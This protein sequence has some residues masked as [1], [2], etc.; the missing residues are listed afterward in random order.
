[1]TFHVSPLLSQT[2]LQY[3]AGRPEKGTAVAKKFDIGDLWDVLRTASVPSRAVIRDCWVKSLTYSISTSP[4]GINVMTSICHLANIGIMDVLKK[5]PVESPSEILMASESNDKVDSQALV[6]Y[7]GATGAKT[8]E[9][10]ELGERMGKNRRLRMEWRSMASKTNIVNKSALD[11]I[12]EVASGMSAE[13]QLEYANAVMPTYQTLAIHYKPNHLLKW[14]SGQQVQAEETPLPGPIKYKK[15]HS[16][17]GAQMY[18]HAW[19]ILKEQENNDWIK[20]HPLVSDLKSAVNGITPVN[21]FGYHDAGINDTFLLLETNEAARW[22]TEM[23][24]Y[25]NNMMASKAFVDDRDN[26][27][28]KESRYIKIRD[29]KIGSMNVN[30]HVAERPVECRI[31]GSGLHHTEIKIHRNLDVL[32]DR[33]R[34][35]A[36]QVHTSSRIVK[37]PPVRRVQ[38]AGIALNTSAAFD[39]MN[40]VAESC[41]MCSKIDGLKDHQEHF[42]AS[43]GVVVTGLSATSNGGA[44]CPDANDETI[45]RTLPFSNDIVQ[46]NWAIDLTNR[47]Y[48]DLLESKLAQFN[49]AVESGHIPGEKIKLED[50]PQQPLPCM[51]FPISTGRKKSKQ[52]FVLQMLSIDPHT[53]ATNTK[54]EVSDEI[55]MGAVMNDI[56]VNEVATSLGRK[57][58]SGDIE[59]YKMDRIGE[60][61]MWGVEGDL[62]AYR[63][64]CCH[65]RESMVAKGNALPEDDDCVVGLMDCELMLI[66]RMHER[67]ASVEGSE[68]AVHEISMAW[69]QTYKAVIKSVKEGKAGKAGKKA[70][71][72]RSIRNPR[73][74]YVEM[75][76][77]PFLKKQK[78]PEPSSTRA[79]SPGL[80][81]AGPSMLTETDTR[82][83]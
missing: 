66:C 12:K 22:C 3:E 60:N 59:S 53:K 70:L 58:T 62:N 21:L 16:Q 74:D 32:V 54:I 10:H 64:W 37:C 27:P 35:P 11:T 77:N 76:D 6:Q 38:G 72:K 47:S 19:I 71:N 45:T 49:N 4:N 8:S 44:E 18:D 23:P 69:A 14:A 7:M 48:I 46:M 57:P 29:V 80:S 40:M 52:S 81:G 15:S 13:K 20:F 83:L 50:M 24:R 78:V 31:E 65:M 36:A 75:Q 51:G 39:H 73:P 34:L 63:T 68:E 26:V 5:M 56:L 30:A 33:A 25:T 17:G 61:Y 79:A 55:N 82:H 41:I 67:R 43:A 2:A 42:N 28:T 9:L 1:M